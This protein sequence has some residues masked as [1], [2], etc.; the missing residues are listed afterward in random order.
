MRKKKEKQGKT[1][2]N[3]EKQGTTREDKGR[4]GKTMKNKENNEKHGKTMI[5]KDKQRKT[6]KQKR[7]QGREAVPRWWLHWAKKVRLG[8]T[9]LCAPPEE[10][11]KNMLNLLTSFPSSAPS[12]GCG[13]TRSIA[14]PKPLSQYPHNARGFQFR[15]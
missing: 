6:R 4:Q 13:Q 7:K 2:K 9:F 15:V 1:R 5:N 8:V 3:N 14:R 12:N 11:N 10:K